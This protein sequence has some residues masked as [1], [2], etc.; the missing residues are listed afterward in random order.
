MKL[1]SLFSGYGGLDLAVHAVLPDVTTAWVS[2]VEPGP[3]TILAHRFPGVPN[4]GD[5]T[6]IDWAEVEPVNI[7]AGGSPCQDLSSAGLRRG[8]KPGTRSGLWE[9]MF[10]AVKT[11]RPQ[12]VVWENVRGALSAPA[13]SLLE[14]DAGRLGN[15][16]SRVVLRALGRVL[17][18][19]ASIGYDAQWEVVR[20]SDVGA[21]H[22]RER[23]FV[24]AYPNG[25]GLRAQ[26]G[27]Q[28]GPAHAPLGGN[29]PLLP[30]PQARDGKGVPGDGY[31][32]ASLPR[33]ISLLPTPTTSDEYQSASSD[34]KRGEADR[35]RAL[36]YARE[37]ARPSQGQG[38][39]QQRSREPHDSLR[40][41]SPEVA[42]GAGPGRADGVDFGPYAPAIQRWEQVLGREAPPPTEPGRSGRPQLS[43]RF[44]EWMM[45]LPAGWVTDVGLSRAN[46]LRALGNGVVPQQGAHA[47][48]ALLGGQDVAIRDA[49]EFIDLPTER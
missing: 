40:E 1:G 30:T 37:T 36:R 26:W 7:I 23:V 31:N 19:L 48:A 16:P 24:V 18:D 41:L 44:C 33:E 10:Q 2:D 35:L 8:M 21:P 4:L 28:S 29:G 6:T 9:S 20:A 47:I 22:R 14:P 11:M 27:E 32:Q 12:L 46:Q 43:P 3:K 13:F 15:G 25:G 17:G 42:L 49:F 39:D 34:G 38:R 45:G 5:I